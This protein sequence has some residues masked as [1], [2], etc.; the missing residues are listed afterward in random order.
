[1]NE[2]LISVIVPV[3]KVEQY[4]ERCV[5][6]IVTQSYEN[7]EIILVDDGSPDNCGAMCDAWAA[8][9]SRIRVIH[10]ENGGAASARNTGVDQCRGEFITFVDSDDYLAQEMIARL[11]EAIVEGCGG[12]SMCNTLCLDK[13]GVPEP[14]DDYLII[15]NGVHPAGD[16]LPRIYQAWGWLFVAPWS[17]LFRREVLRELRYPVGKGTED[18]FIC[19]QLIWEAQTVCMTDY[20]GYCY[21]QERTGSA[22]QSWTSLQKL[23]Y[24]EALLI[25]YRFYQQI[26]QNHLLH[27][28]RARVLKA[29]EQ[30]YWNKP[31]VDPHYDEKMVWLRQEYGKL[32]G[33]PLKERLKWFIFRISPKLEKL[34]LNMK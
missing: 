25:R 11:Y 27:E 3:Y 14:G 33:L 24:F 12:M 29:L 17:K 7:L 6:S 1:M 10:K 26:G 32:T 5:Q 13:N 15:E 21:I 2:P 19:A 4:L 9:D 31:S 18:E 34:L 8:R 30:Y 16:I 20:R 28:T 23:D 22:M